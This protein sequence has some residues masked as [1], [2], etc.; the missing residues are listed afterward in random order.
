VIL[1]RSAKMT[2]SPW[3]RQAVVAEQVLA[4]RDEPRAAWAGTPPNVIPNGSQVSSIGSSCAEQWRG[5]VTVW[6][7]YGPHHSGATIAV[8]DR[9][10]RVA[11]VR[12][13]PRAVPLAAEVVQAWPEA[14]NSL[15]RGPPASVFVRRITNEICRG[16]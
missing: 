9:G 11:A 1:S 10:V 3:A 6:R 15:S 5:V 12:A 13:A 2:V 4:R 16:A 8:L 14:V 7:P